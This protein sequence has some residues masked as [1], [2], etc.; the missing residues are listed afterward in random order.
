M[1]TPS[2]CQKHFVLVF[3]AVLGYD[4]FKKL[5]RLIRRDAPVSRILHHCTCQPVVKVGATRQCGFK[6]CQGFERTEKQ[7]PVGADR[8]IP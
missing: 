3:V 7:D 6:K 5:A 2:T 4:S 8:L 1:G